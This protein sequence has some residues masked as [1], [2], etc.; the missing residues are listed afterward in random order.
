M[1]SPLA[2]LRQ[3]DPTPV[4]GRARHCVDGPALDLRALALAE[5]VPRLHAALSRQVEAPVAPRSG[6]RGARDEAIAFANAMLA[7]DIEGA[8]R[9]VAVLRAGG[10][11][12][13]S[14]FLHVLAPT[15]CHLRDLWSEDLCGLADVT[16]ALCNLRTL[17][18]R[19]ADAFGANGPETGRRALVV[20]MTP[21]GGT[22][23][24]HAL[25]DLSMA[26]LFLRRDG[27]Q[28]RVECGLS[29][30]AVRDAVR[31]EWFDTLAIM[32]R[33]VDLGLDGGVRQ[34][35][36]DAAAAGIRAIRR[37]AANPALRV[38]L[39]G[40]AFAR[41]PELVARLGADV[42]VGDPIAGVARAAQLVARASCD[43]GGSRPGRH[44]RAS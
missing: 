3:S 12:L 10:Q 36:L 20:A 43:D 25:F 19:H 29:H 7:D 4:R 35:A 42:A 40:E 41:S 30:P 24:G 38:I 21:V 28:P 37:E 11:S 22:D 2:D 16:L 18:R 8:C 13:E 23:V 15:A 26:A 34:A 5:V 33:D 17:L 27:W 14:I 39:C 32:A 1:L 9:R 6:E 44:R 31:G